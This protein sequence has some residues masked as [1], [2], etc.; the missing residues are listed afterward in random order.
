MP[1]IK[2]PRKNRKKSWCTFFN[3]QIFSYKLKK[4]HWS[5]VLGSSLGIAL[6]IIISYFSTVFAYNASSVIGQSYNSSGV[7]TTDFVNNCFPNN[8]GLSYPL[9]TE[10]DYIN[11]RMFLADSN[12]D[13]VL[14]YNLDENN[15]LTDYL[16]DNVLGQDSLNGYELNTASQTRMNNP[17]GLVLDPTSSTLYVSDYS[18]GRV[19]VFDVAEITDGE[20]AVH[21]LGQ[22]DFTSHAQLTASSSTINAPKG[23]E[24]NYV[25][26]NLYVT[27]YNRVLIFDIAEITD[28]EP[29]VHVLG[30]TDFTTKATSMSQS[31]FGQPSGLDIT[32]S[33]T[34]FVADFSGRRVLIFDVA[35]ITDGEPAVHVLGQSGFDSYNTVSGINSLS[36]SE[37][38][39]NSTNNKIYTSDSTDN[40]IVVFD[41]ASI[42][43]GEDAIDIIG[44]LDNAN[45]PIFTTDYVNNCTTNINGFNTPTDLALDSINKRLF[46]ADN[47]NNRILVFNLDENND[48]LD[49]TPDNVLGQPDYTSN[50]T[51]YLDSPGAISVGRF[52]SSTYL[53]VA[54]TNKNRVLLYNVDSVSNNQAPNYVLG[55]PDFNT[56]WSD[57]S[58]SSLYLPWGIDFDPISNYL[59]VSELGNN[60]VI[61]YDLSDGVASG[62][63]AY[64]VLGQPD[65]FTADYGTTASQLNNPHGITYE[66][67]TQKLFVAD[68]DNQ[69]ILVYNLSDGI[70]NGE[71]AYRVLGQTDFTSS[72]SA[73][74]KNKFSAS[75]LSVG[76]TTNTLFVGDSTGR[77]L[78]FDITSITN[79]E[80]ALAVIGQTNFTTYSYGTSQ[81]K[82]ASG[83]EGMIPD[84]ENNRFYFSDP[85]NYRIL[86]FDFIKISDSLPAAV[87]GESYSQTIINNYQ[88]TLS[89]EIS[90]GTLPPGLT[91]SGNTLSG[92]PTTFGTYTFTVSTTDDIDSAGYFTDTQ[93]ITLEVSQN[94]T[95]WL[96]R[97]KITIDANQVDTNL[98][99]F[100]VLINFSAD[101]DLATSASSTGADIIFAPSDIEWGTG[102][103]GDR[104]NFQIEK[105]TSSTGELTAWVKIPN[106]S[107]SADTSIYL[108][109]G[110]NAVTEN[111]ETADTWSN[112]YVMVQH[113]SDTAGPA[114]DSTN[115]L[116]HGLL[117]GVTLDATGKIARAG[118]LNGSS[119]FITVATSTSIQTNNLD[120]SLWFKRNTT[121]TID[122]LFD[123]SYTGVGG[124]VYFQSENDNLV[125]A[126]GTTLY[127][128]GT[129]NQSATASAWH[130]LYLQNVNLDTQ[131][132]LFFG[133]STST[134]YFDGLLDE[135]RIAS[136]TR[137][138]EW[139]AAEYTNQNNPEDFYSISPEQ[140][141]SGY[142]LSGWTY[143]KKI[144][145]D[146]DQVAGDLNDFAILVS[147]DSDDDLTTHASSTGGDIVFAPSSEDWATGN[148]NN[149]YAYT[150]SSYNSTSGTLSA[151]V[152][153][154]ELSSLSDTDIYM[155]YGNANAVDLQGEHVQINGSGSNWIT[156]QNNNQNYPADFYLVSP[157]L[158][159]SGT[160]L[161]NWN[162]R[163]K[164]TIAFNYVAD[165][166]VEFPVHINLSSDA[167][168]SAK[169]NADG[170]DILIVPTNFDWTTG[171]TND[172]HMF[173]IV[174]YTS[175][176]G[177][178]EAYVNIPYLSN[179]V[180]TEFYI[181]YGNTSQTSLLKDSNTQNGSSSTTQA[182]SSWTQTVDNNNNDDINFYTLADEEFFNQA[183]YHFT[184][185]GT[186]TMTPSSN[187]IIT[188]SL[189]DN[190][191]N[192]A[193]LYDGNKTIIFSGANADSS[194][195]EPTCTNKDGD[196]ISFGSD[197]I[198]SFTDGVGVCVLTL[199]KEESISIDATSGLL[200]TA[201]IP[202]Y[203]LDI[204][205][206]TIQQATSG[207]GFGYSLKNKGTFKINDGSTIVSSKFVTLHMSPGAE[208]KGMAIAN[209]ESFNGISVEAYKDT[210]DWVLKSGDGL[211]K[212]FVKFWY[213]DGS[214]SGVISAQIILNT[215]PKIISPTEGEKII[216]SPFQITGTANPLGNLSINIGGTTYTIKA[217]K[218]GNFSVDVLDQ[219][220]SKEYEI[221]AWQYDKDGEMGDKT[222]RKIIFSEKKD[223]KI[224]QIT[225]NKK[226]DET[227]SNKIITGTTLPSSITIEARNQIKTKI[228]DK[229][230]F[231]LVL[232]N[233]SANFEE[234]QSG[235]IVVAENEK[236]EMLLRPQQ[237]VHSIVGRLYT[238][239]KKTSELN[240]YQKIRQ[241]I[242]PT[243]YADTNSEMVGAYLFTHD[244]NNNLY[245]L[246]V[247]PPQQNGKEYKLV[248]NINN[249]DGTQVTLNKKMITAERGIIS[250]NN[251]PVK[252]A[253]IEIFQYNQVTGIYETWPG[254]L[255]GTN[256]P[257]FS[258]NNGKYSVALPAGQYQINI[259]APGYQ[260]YTS[261]IFILPKPTII[262][263]NFTLETSKFGWWYKLWERIK[264]I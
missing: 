156:T 116:N 78:V 186:T 184:I 178:L 155:Y 95:D 119:D 92:T 85:S 220:S 9:S 99:N 250:S 191:G 113:L 152:K 69:R 60:R 38:K 47:N 142:A 247:A 88:G 39:Y 173:E 32:S 75:F 89:S 56:I 163:K 107:S 210:A 131:S 101:A 1:Y 237:S 7:F 137:S 43:D 71:D 262:N 228:E 214:D 117:T 42:D 139:I 211:K 244:K 148:T 252:F 175:S 234:D 264:N 4:H 121:N 224:P 150:I 202:S 263:E 127:I 170:P 179:L 80:D 91:L 132:N 17:Q 227:Y 238:A 147:F 65:F 190:S 79:G 235:N 84:S 222:S 82:F 162:Y 94:L 200:S 27:D 11:H 243:V 206:S 203:D 44:Q 197:T 76:F 188:I 35:E 166:L 199:Y 246:V 239:T 245:S 218:K 180:D 114:L 151:W 28:G 73:V 225:P 183:N 31:V 77:I 16:A 257:I 134:D 34:L 70:V 81:S 124:Y 261:K 104:L 129:A 198:I 182:L 21:V 216:S 135:I 14:V 172:R 217:D 25:N 102:T 55:Q 72:G 23:L 248:V 195:N 154:P 259:S 122:Y 260:D 167:D 30:Q 208:A 174:S 20:P 187:Q 258:D 223:L 40:R 41:V 160:N 18:N 66:S 12:N 205:V 181:Y 230:A 108:Y 201:G 196:N 215:K 254:I 120:V 90:S 130:Y 59:F 229:K 54:D 133:N 109:Y 5:I 8:K 164:I 165:A 105:Y 100:P 98:T 45:S 97:K 33:N 49:Y 241:F 171:N 193:L 13:R 125:S 177:A 128:D 51:A 212:V 140:I 219:L 87:V 145:I 209:D 3:T 213:T 236:V 158:V 161:S 136:T 26:K 10:I 48:L 232:K 110:N 68:T 50:N 141:Q 123:K 29:A 168:L 138:A 240:W 194:D 249:E 6:I 253:R 251:K 233:S 207:G 149:R 37:I 103:A 242:L 83:P 74:T 176:T 58:T 126:E 169:A 231:L 189:L 53:F 256:N 96:Y 63:D 46:V 221:T 146:A 57:I 64:R 192:P 226:I 157:E 2:N 36:P 185:T 24:L 93:E 106:L 159:S 115:N 118:S 67:D 144:T 19:L 61:I 22:T 204:V 52:N 153:I 15:D 62:E 111:L 255:Y 86:I 112:D 143:R